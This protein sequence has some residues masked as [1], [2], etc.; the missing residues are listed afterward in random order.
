MR[1]GE[2]RVR[3]TAIMLAALLLGIGITGVTSA[4]AFAADGRSAAGPAKDANGT[5]PAY[6]VDIRESGRILRPLQR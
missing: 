6:S 1:E 2:V 4:S 3:W 5:K